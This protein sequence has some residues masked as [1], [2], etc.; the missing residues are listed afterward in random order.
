MLFRTIKPLLVDAVQ[1]KEPADVQT[2]TGVVHVNRGD[3]LVRDPQGNLVRYDDISFKCTYERLEGP[4]RLED[5]SEGKP[6]G[7]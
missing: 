2:T 4:T 6:C 5:V 7:C 1:A 3:W